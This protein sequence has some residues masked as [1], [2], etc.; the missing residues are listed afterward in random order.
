M[1][2]I[3]SI[4]NNRKKIIKKALS[5]ICMSAG[6]AT[7]CDELNQILD[8]LNLY[9]YYNYAR[10]HISNRMEDSMTQWKKIV[11]NVNEWDCNKTISH[12]GFLTENDTLI[13]YNTDVEKFIEYNRCNDG[14]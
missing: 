11:I 1:N 12:F 5:D 9:D 6:L 8:A 3:E 2:I 7:N 14:E 4:I 10:S 13:A